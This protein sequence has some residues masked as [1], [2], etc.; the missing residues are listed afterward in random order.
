MFAHTL[1]VASIKQDW[2]V[3][4][5][6][7]LLAPCRLSPFPAT[8]IAFVLPEKSFTLKGLNHAIHRKSRS[9]TGRQPYP[10][11]LIDLGSDC[12]CASRRMRTS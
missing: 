6:S 3:K 10:E 8:A 2:E 12:F 5:G 4:I 1:L 9:H 7:P 11:M